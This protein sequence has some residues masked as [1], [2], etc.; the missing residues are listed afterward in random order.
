MQSPD[1]PLETM[2]VN[3]TPCRTPPMKLIPSGIT[4]PGL[5]VG[6][7]ISPAPLVTS[8]IRQRSQSLQSLILLEI[9]AFED[10]ENTSRSSSLLFEVSELTLPGT[11]LVTLIPTTVT[12]EK[13]NN[14]DEACRLCPI[15]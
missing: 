4:P 10:G 13:H 8:T 6:P 9:S 7:R 2:R 11:P 12:R 14:E 5:P 3:N 15:C 1:S